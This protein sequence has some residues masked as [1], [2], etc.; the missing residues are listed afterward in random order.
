MFRI[1]LAALGCLIFAAGSSA[2]ADLAA[3]FSRLEDTW[4]AELSP[5]GKSLAYGCQYQNNRAVCIIPLAEGGMDSTVYPSAGESRIIDFY[6]ASNQH[7][8]MVTDGTG[9]G[10]LSTGVQTVRFNRAI[11]FNATNGKSAMLLK[12]YTNYSSTTNVRSLFESKPDK[13]I[14]ALLVGQNTRGGSGINRRRSDTE[15]FY[16]PFEVDLDSG[17]AKKLRG[18]GDAVVDVLYDGNG[19]DLIRTI[20]D[21]NTNDFE[22]KDGN[23]RVIYD[24]KGSPLRH[25]YVLSFTEDGQDLLV[26]SEGQSVSGLQRGVWKMSMDTGAVSRIE[27]EGFTV[28]EHS[29]V[30]DPHTNR[31]V[32]YRFS[33]DLSGQ[34]FVDPELKGY[35]EAI[36]E[37]MPEARVQLRSWSDD[38]SR[39]I[40]TIETA[41]RP[42]QY[43]IFQPETFSLTLIGVSNEVAAERLLGAVEKV[44]YKAADG[45]D[46]PGYLTLP[47]GKTM[48]DAPFPVI[49]LP[50]G[51]PDASDTAAFD[52]WSQ[53]YAAAGY[54]VL[55]PNF[56]GSNRFGA[57]FREAG[58]GE[59][60]GKMVTDVTDGLAWLEAEGIAKPGG[61][62]VVGASYGGYSALMAP[63]LRP[64]VVKCAISVNGVTDPIAQ[65]GRYRQNNIEVVSYWEQYMGST[66]ASAEQHASITPLDRV[67]EYRTP[68]LLI[69]GDA[70]TRVEFGQFE[71][72]TKAAGN[73]SWLTTS[74]MRGQD[75]FLYTQE[76]REQMLTESLAFLAQHHPVE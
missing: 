54:A 11:S 25:L 3:D 48:E 75:H 41:G 59:F 62:C 68:V 76:A 23:N 37:A 36:S 12:D 35:Q 52:W 72:F 43:L 28:I 63:L 65:M 24:N 60:G 34:V 64:D 5:N 27:R 20:W 56:R 17:K 53:A 15:L 9:I 2:N 66:F 33:D 47:E 61:A 40:V 58:F 6:W 18:Y 74:V 67:S 51:G 38:R 30:I 73:P 70:D 71:A 39:F 45:L 69:H 42:I 8:V 14:M 19:N 46:I 4:A 50:H 49:L 31:A 22:I 21:E 13:V 29:P 57:E 10:E 26:W 16:Q 44:S 32:G 7:V 1:V 55:Q